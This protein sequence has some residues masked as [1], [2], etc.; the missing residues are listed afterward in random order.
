MGRYEEIW[1]S[2]SFEHRTL[3]VSGDGFDAGRTDSVTVNK[4]FL[5]V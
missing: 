5:F 1:T 3:G 2:G 4:L